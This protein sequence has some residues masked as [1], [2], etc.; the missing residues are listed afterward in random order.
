VVASFLQVVGCREGDAELVV[1]PV[2]CVDEEWSGEEEAEEVMGVMAGE[3]D[4]EVVW[5]RDLEVDDGVDEE[6]GVMGGLE[7]A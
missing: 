5:L 2:N 1:A 7:S 6:R 4:G 3:N